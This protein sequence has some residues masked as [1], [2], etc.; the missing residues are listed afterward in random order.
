M[1]FRNLIPIRNI[2]MIKNIPFKII[3]WKARLNLSIS[4]RGIVSMKEQKFE[5]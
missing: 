1:L 5:V 3:T 4:D 2:E